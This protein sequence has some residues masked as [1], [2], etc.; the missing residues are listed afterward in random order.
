MRCLCHVIEH[1]RKART[2]YYATNIVSVGSLPMV[3]HLFT[4]E[5]KSALVK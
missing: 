2:L 1:T 4:R 5:L 3:L